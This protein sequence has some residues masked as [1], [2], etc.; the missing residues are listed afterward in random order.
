LFQALLF[1]EK[2]TMAGL[3]KALPLAL[4][5]SALALLGACDNGPSAVSKQA[6]GT[7]MATATAPERFDGAASAT[8]RVDHRKDT[9]ATADDGK[10]MWA[11]SRRSSA[12]EGAQRAFERNGAAFGAA[13]VDAFVGKAHAFV[14]YPPAGAET[15]T[16]ANGDRMIYDPG[17]NVFAVVS[18][19]GA[20]RTMFKPDDGPAYWAAQKARETKRDDDRG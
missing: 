18:K 11:P 5:I 1:Q 12:E 20:P 10:P 2:K 8:P 4:G 15:V 7:Q 17:S 16:R 9:V 13:S 3:R 14:D 19:A 6:A